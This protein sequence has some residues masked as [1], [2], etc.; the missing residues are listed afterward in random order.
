MPYIKATD[1]TDLF[2][3]DWPGGRPIVFVHAWAL[4]S[5]MWDYQIPDLTAA[6]FRCITF[7]RRG[8]GRSDRPG[9]GYD[10]DTLADDLASV[11][12]TLDPVREFPS[13]GIGYARCKMKYV[14][15]SI[16]ARD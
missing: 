16:V 15:M 13:A 12:E 3:T 4:N 9:V 2:Y 11:L 10:L 1:G 6:G 14:N 5:C 8:H 7:D